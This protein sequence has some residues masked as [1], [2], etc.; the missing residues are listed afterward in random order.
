MDALETALRENRAYLCLSCGKCTAVCPVARKDAGFSPRRLV[1]RAVNDDPSTWLGGDEVWKCLTCLRCSALC[2][3][4][5]RFSEFT[6]D[7]RALARESG[8]AG[9]CTHG[10]A[11]FAWMRLMQEPDL[12][13]NRLDWLTADLQVSDDGDTL[14]FVGCLLHYDVMFRAQGFEGVAIAQ[15]TVR[16]LNRMGIAPRVLADERCC[17]HDLLW[18]GD[19]EGFRKLA[20]LNAALF[21]QAG[22]RRIVTSCAECY[23]TLKLDYPEACGLKVELLHISQVLAQAVAE[24]TIAFRRDAPPMAFHDPCRLGRHAGEYDAPRAVLQAAAELREMEHARER[25]LCC[26]TSVW[27]QCGQVAKALQDERIAEALAASAEVMVTA[28]PKCQIH[29]TCAMSG[30][31]SASGRRVAVRDLVCV[32]ADAVVRR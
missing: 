26:G 20:R 11:I 23:R 5:V 7:V 6:R 29:F 2:P 17:G 32:L 31:A 19:V 12:R 28:C 8:N 13:Q 1:E 25:A 24:G 21:A 10:D 4:G 15:S 16:L 3:G 22:I 18:A 27:T 30:P 14:Y 9:A